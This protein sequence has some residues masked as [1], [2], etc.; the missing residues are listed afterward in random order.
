MAVPKD[1]Q[2]NYAAQGLNTLHDQIFALVCDLDASTLVSESQSQSA[3][4]GKSEFTD[5]N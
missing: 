5:F 1:R 4:S 3:G 2:L